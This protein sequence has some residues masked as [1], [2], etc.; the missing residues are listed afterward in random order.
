MKVEMCHLG[1]FLSQDCILKGKQVEPLLEAWNCKYAV[2][3]THRWRKRERVVHS[4]E[5]GWL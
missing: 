3:S 2:T 4:R 5:N 1:V